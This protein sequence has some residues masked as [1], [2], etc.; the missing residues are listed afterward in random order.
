MEAFFCWCTGGRYLDL[1]LG[2][3][4]T[5]YE[6]EEVQGLFDRETQTGRNRNRDHTVNRIMLGQLAL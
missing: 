1:L 6:P 5:K 3:N 2:E 4:I